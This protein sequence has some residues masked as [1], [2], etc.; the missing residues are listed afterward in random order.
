MSR[1]NWGLFLLTGL[2]WGIPYLLMKVAV[3]DLSPVVIVFSRVLIGSLILIFV[4]SFPMHLARWLVLG[5]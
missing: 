4:M 2:L 1:K 3:R 5:F